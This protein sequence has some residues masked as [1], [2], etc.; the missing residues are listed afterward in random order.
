MEVVDEL[1]NNAKNYACTKNIQKLDVYGDR[2][3]FY[4]LFNISFNNE[5]F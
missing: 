3:K 1:D 5:I 4:F 2:Y